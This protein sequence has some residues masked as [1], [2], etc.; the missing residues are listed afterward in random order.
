MK[1]IV[2]LVIGIVIFLV[3]LY[4]V[5]KNKPKFGAFLII[6]S[7]VCG[8]VIANYDEITKITWPGGDI[9]KTKTEFKAEVISIKDEAL[10][11]ITSE[12]E[13]Q[14]TVLEN[15]LKEVER[16]KSELEEV[17]LK[18]EDTI[19]EIEHLTDL[20]KDLTLTYTKIAWLQSQTKNE[21]GTDRDMKARQEIV[22]ELNRLL[23]QVFPND[24]ERSLWIQELNT[25][26]E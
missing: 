14:K 23:P 18:S 7:L 13:S 21:F 25:A 22:N 4:S 5:N 10:K 8:F 19:K 11:N 24:L 17:S 6:F 16:Q 3:G 12:I 1:E 9:E 26:L 2:A 15:L 20:S